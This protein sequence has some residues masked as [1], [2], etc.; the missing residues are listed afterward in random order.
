MLYPGQSLTRYAISKNFEIDL[1]TNKIKDKR[2][3]SQKDYNNINTKILVYEDRQKEWFFNI[4]E[5]LKK[6]NEA[7]FVIL[8]LA[9]SYLESNQQYRE[10][11]SSEGKSEDFFKKA[12][13]RVFPRVT[14]NQKNLL[15]KEMRCGFFH[16]G[17]TRKTIF[18][19]GEQKGILKEERGNL[20][21]NPHLFFDAIRMDFEKYIS[22]IKEKSNHLE[23]ENFEK[24]WDDFKGI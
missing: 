24:F 19:T 15:Y 11:E 8:M 16:D 14:E 6:N 22:F 17:I 4:A 18:I 7:G 2:N 1:T 21:I 10:G 23:R 3:G 5:E 13:A 20:I 9:S 12:L